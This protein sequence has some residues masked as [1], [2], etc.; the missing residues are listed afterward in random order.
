M[1]ELNCQPHA[2]SPEPGLEVVPMDAGDQA[3]PVLEA[4]GSLAPHFTA[5]CQPPSA[6]LCPPLRAQPPEGPLV[7]GLPC[8]ARLVLWACAP[9]GLRYLFPTAS[10]RSPGSP[11]PTAFSSSSP[12]VTVFLAPPRLLG[13][14][15]GFH[16]GSGRWEKGAPESWVHP[17]SGMQLAPCP[18]WFLN[19]GVEEA[20]L[21]RGANWPPPPQDADVAVGS[22]SCFPSLFACLR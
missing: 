2:P 13:S 16:P 8:S 14:S 15:R 19:A 12:E 3:D 10:F 5:G 17:C 20:A 7:W 4:G 11:P 18:S 6:S 1:T 22:K 21:R 9:P